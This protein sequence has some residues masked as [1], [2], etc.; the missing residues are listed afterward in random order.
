MN[1]SREDYAN[2]LIKSCVQTCSWCKKHLKESCFLSGKSNDR[3]RFV[4]IIWEQA[5]WSVNGEGKVMWMGNGSRED[6]AN[7]LIKS[8]VQT[9]S[10]CSWCK[11]HLRESC[12]LSENQTVEVGFYW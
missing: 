9:C 10:W 2:G 3:S 4:L 8:C 11:K 5:K 1:G 12:F 7:G 6:Y